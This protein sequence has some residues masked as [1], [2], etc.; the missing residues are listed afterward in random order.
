MIKSLRARL[1]VYSIKIY[2][3]L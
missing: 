2:K 3:N 1:A